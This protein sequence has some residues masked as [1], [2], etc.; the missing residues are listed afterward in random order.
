MISTS[1]LVVLI[2]S[3]IV[4]GATGMVLDG[5]L[6]GT[7]LAIVAGFLAVI[8]AAFARN[9]IVHRGIGVGPD[10]SSLPAVIIT[11]AVVASLAG[12][13]AAAEIVETELHL[14]NSML[15]VFSGLFSGILMALLMLT[16]H[17]NP[18]KRGNLI[19]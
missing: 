5:V 1:L 10:D 13:L 9:M 11:Y 14:P 3:I 19:K 18:D 8:A 2:V 12:S 17:M 6:S 16:Y 15:G 4:G 7:A